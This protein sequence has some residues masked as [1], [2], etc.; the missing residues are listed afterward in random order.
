[1]GR[2]RV[3]KKYRCSLCGSVFKREKNQAWIK[4]YCDVCDL[5]SHCYKVKEVK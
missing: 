3:I 4:S 1:M 2:K 5:P